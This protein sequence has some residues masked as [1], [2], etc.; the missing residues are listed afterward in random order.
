MKPGDLVVYSLKGTETQPAPDSIQLMVTHPDDTN[1]KFSGRFSVRDVGIV[2]EPPCE[3]L[4]YG[5]W[6]KIL[7]SGV[8]GWVV[9]S[10]VSEVSEVT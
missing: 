7:C 6:V 1:A 10:E 3:D 9:L 4:F 2:L 5:V 8:I